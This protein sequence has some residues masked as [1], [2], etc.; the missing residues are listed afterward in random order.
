[1]TYQLTLSTAQE[2]GTRD[3]DV[4]ENVVF[5][6]IPRNYEVYLLCYPGA[7]MNENLRQE[8]EKYGTYGGEMLFVNFA[9]KLDR[10]Y[11]MIRD[12]FDINTFPTIIM[13]G[14]EKLA[15]PPADYCTAYVKMDNKELLNSPE[16]AMEC[17]DRVF[18][19]FLEGEVSKAMQVQTRSAREA[20]LKDIV[21]H[22]LTGVLGFLRQ[23]EIDVSFIEGRFNLTPVSGGAGS[24]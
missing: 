7:N 14:V 12:M 17:V 19:L 21:T 13:T 9:T 11:G 15:S 20:R 22:T 24:A 8:L 1:M 6:D 16:L 4:F 23:W 2:S 5:K 18:H 10:N 3:K